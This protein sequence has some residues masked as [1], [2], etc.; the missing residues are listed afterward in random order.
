MSFSFVLSFLSLKW[1]IALFYTPGFSNILHR[2]SLCILQCQH[3]E[4][5]IWVYVFRHCHN[6]NKKYQWIWIQ[7]TSSE[8]K[9]LTRGVG[10]NLLV[11]FV[12][13]A[14]GSAPAEAGVSPATIKIQKGQDLIANITHPENLNYSLM[15]AVMAGCKNIEYSNLRSQTIKDLQTFLRFVEVERQCTCRLSKHYMSLLSNLMML[16]CST[17]IRLMSMHWHLFQQLLLTE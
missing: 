11:T 5:S 3:S 10:N 15:G 13:G 6:T 8:K 14:L 2:A 9:A 7:T 12:Q 17:K 1:K 16:H 4:V